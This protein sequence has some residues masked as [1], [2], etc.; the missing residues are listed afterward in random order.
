MSDIP[1]ERARD[2]DPAATLGT[3]GRPD[4]LAI[5]NAAAGSSGEEALAAAMVALRARADVELVVPADVDELRAALEV[6]GERRVAV[7]GGDGSVHATVNALVDLGMLERVGPIAVIPL[8]TGNDIARAVG[9]PLEPAEAVEAVLDGVPHAL[10]LLRDDDGKIAVNAVHVGVG[11][12]AAARVGD[13][14][15]P[16]GEAAY[17]LGA[18]RAG[19]TEGSWRLRVTVDGSVLHDGS[20]PVLMVAL[21]LGSTIGGGAPVTPDASPEDGVAEVVVSAATGPL[22]RV[23][24]GLAMLRGDHVERDDVLTAS[25]RVV[26]VEAVDADNAFRTNADGEVRGPF[27]SRTWTLVPRGWQLLAPR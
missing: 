16:L 18:V 6:V 20:E 9:I 26:T 3:E 27:T 5:G 8:G 17:A 11:A 19:A 22:A 1:A 4:V 24:Y 23:G 7:L 15:G 10:D 2:D 25:G 21:G 13:A 12:E 14:K